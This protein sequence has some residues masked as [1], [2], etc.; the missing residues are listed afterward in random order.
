MKV[1][2][3]QLFRTRHGLMEVYCIHREDT[4]VKV[5]LRQDCLLIINVPCSIKYLKPTRQRSHKW[6]IKHKIIYE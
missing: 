5:D 3:G 1:K 4:I 2:L 6:K